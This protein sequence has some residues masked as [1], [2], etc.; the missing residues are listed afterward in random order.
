V[1]EIDGEPIGDF[2]EAVDR[3]Q[4]ALDNEEADEIV[5]LVRR[6]N[7]TSVLRIRKQ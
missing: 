2:G 6:S 4:A 7:E 3:M 1:Q 5:L